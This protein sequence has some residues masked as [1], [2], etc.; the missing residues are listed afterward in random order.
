[1]FTVGV[2]F[3]GEGEVWESTAAG[4]WEGVFAFDAVEVAVEEAGVAVVAEE[5]EGVGEGFEEGFDGGF[6]GL[7]GLGVVVHY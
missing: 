4:G 2:E 7:V 5:D 1:M 3:A 6:E